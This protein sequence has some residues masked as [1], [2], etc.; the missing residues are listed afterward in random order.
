MHDVS[1]ACIVAIVIVIYIISKRR[2]RSQSV[3]QEMQLRKSIEPVAQK[4]EHVLSKGCPLD[5]HPKIKPQPPSLNEENCDLRMKE[6]IIKG[7]DEETDKGT[8]NGVIGDDEFI[9]ATKGNNSAIEG[10]K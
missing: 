2:D 10:N 5:N 9:V 8:I 3:I 1:I 7:E 6:I 4:K